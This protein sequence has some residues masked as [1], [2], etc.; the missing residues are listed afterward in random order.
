MSKFKC[1]HCNNEVNMILVLEGFKGCTSCLGDKYKNK[2]VRE[3]N[4]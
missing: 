2:K 1:R 3:L 4:V